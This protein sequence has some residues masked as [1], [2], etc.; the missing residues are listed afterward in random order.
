M[1][2]AR[3]A[4]RYDANYGSISFARGTTQWVSDVTNSAGTSLHYQRMVPAPTW[5]SQPICSPRAPTCPSATSRA[6]PD[7]SD[8]TVVVRLA[9]APGTT[10]I[11]S[12]AVADFQAACHATGCATVR[13]RSS[14]GAPPPG[15]DGLSS[16]R[17]SA[18]EATVALCEKFAPP[19]GSRL[20]SLDVNFSERRGGARWTRGLIAVRLVPF[21]PA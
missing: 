9:F 14:A 13:L 7:P 19:R 20:L 16:W 10:E 5:A 18:G 21:A 11:I 15:C 1:I 4:A 2:P 6:W 8:G 17:G 3:G 12:S